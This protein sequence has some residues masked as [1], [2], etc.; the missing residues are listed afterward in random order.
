M[1]KIVLFTT[2][3]LLAA[4]SASAQQLLADANND[5]K[6]SLTEYQNSRRTFLMR[7]DRD[8]D[9]KISAAEWSKGAE[10]LKSEIRDSGVDGWPIIGKAGIFEALD[11]N[12]DGFVTPAEIDAATAARF[13]KYDLD[14]DGFIT[15]TEARTLDRMATSKPKP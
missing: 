6:V 2:L 14:H 3:A 9:G 1:R 4:S 12:K 15:R 13:A 5:G 7:A 10:Y 8:K 11:S